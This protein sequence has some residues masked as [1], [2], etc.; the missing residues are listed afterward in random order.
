MDGFLAEGRLS[1]FFLSVTGACRC[2]R[3]GGDPVFAYVGA[4]DGGRRG[5]SG[6]RRGA[7]GRIFTADEIFTAH[8]GVKV[9][10]VVA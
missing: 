8:S 4:G 3:W 7:A 2:C 5:C 1:Q 6:A 10:P 9:H